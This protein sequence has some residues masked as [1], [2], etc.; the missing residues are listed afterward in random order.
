MTRRLVAAIR[1]FCDQFPRLKARLRTCQTNRNGNRGRKFWSCANPDEY[2]CVNRPPS[3]PSA[4]VDPPCP[5]ADVYGLQLRT[6]TFSSGT[7]SWRT[8]ATPVP[9]FCTAM[10][11]TTM[12]TATGSA[13]ATL[14]RRRDSCLTSATKV[15]ERPLRVN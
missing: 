13:T 11:A 8:R 1:C 4:F 3:H 5:R 10:A 14:R 7:T 15:E 2:W 6:A 12:T 9:R